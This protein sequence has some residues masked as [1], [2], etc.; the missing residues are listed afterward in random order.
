MINGDKIVS[1]T[2]FAMQNTY[3][4]EITRVILIHQNSVM[5]LTTSITTTT[6]M[7]SVFADTT[8]TRTNVASLLPVV[9]Q[10]GWLHVE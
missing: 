6:R 7:G 9:M 4:S 5:M 1:E 8:V 2:K 10:S 3:L